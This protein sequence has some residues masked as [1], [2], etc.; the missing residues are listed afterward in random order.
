MKGEQTFMDKPLTSVYLD[1]STG[2][3]VEI[4]QASLKKEPREIIIRQILHEKGIT[5]HSA[6]ELT[7]FIA[8]N[9][10]EGNVFPY[11]QRQ[12]AKL[13][14]RSTAAVNR[15]MKELTTSGIIRRAGNTCIMDSQIAE[16]CKPGRKDIGILYK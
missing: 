16:L 4:F 7:L 10:L 2:T 6:P 8:S 9:L 12:V 13:S 14:G 3:S 11:S 5:L 1:T 15:V